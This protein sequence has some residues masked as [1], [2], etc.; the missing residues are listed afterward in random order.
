MLVIIARVK[1]GIT[2]SHWYRI[3]A[4][5]TLFIKSKI[6]SSNCLWAFIKTKIQI[7][8]LT[9]VK[10]FMRQKAIIL[11]GIWIDLI[12]LW[13]QRYWWEDLI[14]VLSQKIT[15]FKYLKYIQVLEVHNQSWILQ[16]VELRQQKGLNWILRKIPKTMDYN[17]EV[18]L[19]II[20]ITQQPIKINRW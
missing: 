16:K 4:R 11:W 12:S 9:I 1:R 10:V 20:D 17:Q 19:L 6:R 13:A 14:I 2:L 8:G 15:K 5:H 7:Q 3:T 18:I